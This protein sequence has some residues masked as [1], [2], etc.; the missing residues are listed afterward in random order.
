MTS[1]ESAKFLSSAN[2]LVPQTIFDRGS[3]DMDDSE[4]M[5]EIR[6]LLYEMIK[7]NFPMGVSSTHLAKKYNEEYVEKGIGRALPDDWLQQV[8]AAEEFEAQTRGPITILFIRLQNTSSFKRPPINHV[9]VRL[10]TSGGEPSEEE[11]KQQKLRKENEPLVYAKTLS[12]TSKTLQEGTEILVVA[13]ESCQNIHIRSAEDDANFNKISKT[14]DELFSQEAKGPLD[15]RVAIYEVVKG[16]AYALKDSNGSWFRVVTLD[17]PHSGMVECLFIDVGVSDKY[18]V[19]AL[20]LLPSADHPVMAINAMAKKVSLGIG[21]SGTIFQKG[22]LTNQLTMLIFNQVDSPS[23]KTF[24]P[25]ILKLESMVEKPEGTIVELIGETGLKI[26]EQLLGAVA[27]SQRIT[28]A[29]SPPKKESSPSMSPFS[30]VNCS[31][32]GDSVIEPMDPTKMPAN[33]FPANALFA[34]GPNDISLRQ[35]SLDPMPDY[36]YS[37][38]KEECTLPEA[39]LTED[40]KP[41]GFYA[42]LMDNRWERVQLLQQSKID[43]LAYCVYLI[44]VGAFHYVRKEMLRKL[45]AKSPFK[46]VLMFKCKLADVQPIDGETWNR[47]SHEAVR[48]FFEAACGQPVTVEP[49]PNEDWT[50][51]KQY[52]APPVPQCTARINCCGKDLGDWLV[53]CGL[54]THL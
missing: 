7:K 14:L 6:E 43:K 26:S 48:E 36:M 13:M 19:N 32:D 37:K 42:A 24:T 28:K 51:W 38:L 21:E 20:R 29:P 54:A 8:T 5:E 25:K 22:K 34:A 41:R 50:V 1:P 27:N 17:R 40:P 46:K 12:K 4:E 52:N 11:L 10:I 53:A 45:N 39:K 31:F 3:D 15:S 44:D 23:G 18:P 35:L 47:E 33:S 16:G 9:N 30:P 2:G 49:I